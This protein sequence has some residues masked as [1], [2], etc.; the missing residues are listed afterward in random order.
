MQL[1]NELNKIKRVWI[2]I[3][4]N[5]LGIKSISESLA[6][7][8]VEI[9]DGRTTGGIFVLGPHYKSIMIVIVTRENATIF[10]DLV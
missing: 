1:R 8:D 2:A 9:N 4:E 10:E 7:I 3:N 6:S 5:V